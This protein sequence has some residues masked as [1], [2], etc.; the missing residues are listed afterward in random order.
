ML[1]GRRAQS[2]DR[3][4]ERHELGHKRAMVESPASRWQFESRTF[5]FYAQALRKTLNS[6]YEMLKLK[7]KICDWGLGQVSDRGTM[8]VVEEQDEWGGS[9]A[10]AE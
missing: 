1:V 8:M 9:G 2:R 6:R 3:A 10:G 7:K 4:G 5:S